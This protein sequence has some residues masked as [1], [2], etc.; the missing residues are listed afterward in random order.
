MILC[1]LLDNAIEVTSKSQN[2][3][4]AIYL[5]CAR[6]KSNQDYSILISYTV[7]K[8]LGNLGYDMFFSLIPL[9]ILHFFNLNLCGLT[10][11]IIFGLIRLLQNCPSILQDAMKYAQTTLRNIK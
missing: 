3:S 1:N 10:I 5:L 4:V 7:F 11:S 6:I 2:L 8:I 9:H